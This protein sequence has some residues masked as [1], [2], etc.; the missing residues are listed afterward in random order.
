MF[1]SSSASSGRDIP[2]LLGSAVIASLACLGVVAA[3]KKGLLPPKPKPAKGA[4]KAATVPRET[5]VAVMTEIA[6][7]A[8]EKLE[9]LPLAMNQ[10]KQA[11]LAYAQRGMRMGR[12]DITKVWQSL[13]TNDSGSVLSSHGVTDDACQATLAALLGRGDKE[14]AKLEKRILAAAPLAGV[15]AARAVRAMEATTELEMGIWS[16][17]AAHIAKTRPTLAKGSKAFSRA[18]RA[19]YQLRARRPA[20]L[21]APW[22]KDVSELPDHL[23]RPTAIT[24]CVMT[25]ARVWNPARAAVWSDIIAD[26][27]VTEESVRSAG[28]R[29]GA[30][31][32]RFVIGLGVIGG[33]LPGGAEAEEEEGEG[34]EGGPGGMMMPP[35]MGF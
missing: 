31:E 4:G 11:M 27:A 32:N 17:A 18:V 26:V 1:P 7:L 21:P 25:L 30:Q 12:I 28:A 10:Q 16:D 2:V 35:G 6:D 34:E 29:L 33:T 23:A 20:P 24:A 9:D 22:N 8:E 15:T 19:E 14:V 13:V 3:T 5:L